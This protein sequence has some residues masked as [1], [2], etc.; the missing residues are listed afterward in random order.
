M[1]NKYLIEHEKR[2]NICKPKEVTK[3]EKD[4][5]V[6]TSLFLNI[7]TI[8]RV[9]ELARRKEWKIS[10]MY[11]ALLDYAVE[12][13]ENEKVESQLVEVLQAQMEEV[14]KRVLKT[15]STETLFG[16]VKKQADRLAFLTIG[17]ERY[18]G[19][20]YKLVR[21][22]AEELFFPKEKDSKIKE[23]RGKID[24]ELGNELKIPLRQI[25]LGWLVRNGHP[26]LAKEIGI[27]EEKRKAGKTNG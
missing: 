13:F 16:E 20:S 7:E 27:R 18:A 17:A 15:L 8:N 9:R 12:C 3:M 26:D 21:Y 10:A 6:S 24:T 5:K 22:L 11:R 14:G 4:R 23:L 1:G 25:V 19:A 2:K